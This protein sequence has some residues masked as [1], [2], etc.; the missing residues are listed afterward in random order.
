[1][2]NL[3]LLNLNEKRGFTVKRK[4]LLSLILLY[5]LFLENSVLFEKFFYLYI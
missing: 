1:M 3:G 2:V 5:G 4:G